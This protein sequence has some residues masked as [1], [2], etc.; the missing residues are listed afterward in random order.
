MGFE[1]KW[2]DDREYAFVSDKTSAKF[3][4]L[5]LFNQPSIHFPGW[6]VNHTTNWEDYLFGRWIL[7]EPSTSPRYSDS[8]TL[9]YHHYVL[10]MTVNVETPKS[11]GR[12]FRMTTTA[13]IQTHLYAA[14]DLEYFNLET[15]LSEIVRTGE[16]ATIRPITNQIKLPLLPDRLLYPWLDCVHQQ[17]NSPEIQNWLLRK[18]SKLTARLLPHFPT[19]LVPLILSFILGQQLFQSKKN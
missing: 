8:I 16:L 7:E 10:S 14:I 4:S 19:V 1:Y 15:D 6:N 17:F 12:V 3:K 13:K 2:I 9:A 18:S 11:R 5:K